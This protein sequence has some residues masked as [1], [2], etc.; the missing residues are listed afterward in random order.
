MASAMR[1]AVTAGRQLA[2][3]L[4]SCLL[5]MEEVMVLRMAAGPR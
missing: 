2:D 1:L 3:G 5:M 4:Y